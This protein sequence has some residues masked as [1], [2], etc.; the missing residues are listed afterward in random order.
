M[1]LKP[2]WKTVNRPAASDSETRAGG[3]GGVLSVFSARWR[4]RNSWSSWRRRV[5]VPALAPS[6]VR[7]SKLKRI[8]AQDHGYQDLP[9]LPGDGGAVQPVGERV[10]QEGSRCWLGLERQVFLRNW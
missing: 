9:E 4:A 10:S 8:V 7:T 5:W 3:G 1:L 2:S 6:L